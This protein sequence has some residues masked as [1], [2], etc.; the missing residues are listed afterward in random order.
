MHEMGIAESI[1]AAVEAEMARHAG[2]RAARVGVRVGELSAVEPDSLRFCFEV[3]VKDTAHE[4]LR[5]EIETV[6]RR[7][8]CDACR[9]EFT[10]RDYDFHCPG[11]GGW[12][13]TCAGGDELALTFLELEE[14]GDDSARAQSPR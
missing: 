11:C 7:H 3:L 12:R 10:V 13:A 4:G 6:P 8:R 14:D 9:Q 5:I 1:L 2:A